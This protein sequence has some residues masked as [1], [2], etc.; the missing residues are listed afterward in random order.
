MTLLEKQQL[1]ARQFANL[2]TYAFSL[3]YDVTIGEV[4][5]SKEQAELN[6]K[7]GKGIKNS[8]HILRLAGDLHLFDDGHYL[9]KTEDHRQLGKYWES[10]S[11]DKVKFRWGGRFGDG[12]H[13]SI[14]HEGRA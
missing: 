3:G 6:A 2:I 1:F 8:L 10:L 13:Y 4:E 5:R 11:T 12:N 14:E 9:D 7:Q